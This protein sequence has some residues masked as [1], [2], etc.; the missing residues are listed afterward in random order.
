MFGFDIMI[1]VLM[2]PGILI[3]LTFHEFAHGYVAYILG[4][5]TAKLRGRLTLNPIAHL[6]PLG[7]LALLLAGFG[8]AKPVPVN[9]LMFRERKKGMI[10]VS[11]AGPLMNFFI[12]FVTLIIIYISYYVFNIENEIYNLIMN[13]I[14]QVNIGLGVF[15]LIPVPPLDGSKILAG[16]L[17]YKYEYQMIRMQQY[18]YIILIVL[19]Y[20]GIAG[21]ILEPMRNV[22]DMALNGIVGLFF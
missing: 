5:D 4:D 20:T 14:Y 11:L 12:A 10:L 8:W 22:I 3:G 18:S 9:P 15:N 6:D 16:F 19:L 7:F 21:F 1:K 17:P 13:L 2:L